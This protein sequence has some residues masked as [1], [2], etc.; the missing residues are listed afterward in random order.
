[1][2]RRAHATAAPA[3]QSLTVAPEQLRWRCATETLGFT[4]TSDVPQL[5]GTVGQARG[6]EAISLSLAIDSD[7]FNVY[8]AGPPGT[9]RASTVRRMLTDAAR[10]RPTSNDWCYLHNFDD[11]N[12]PVAVQLASGR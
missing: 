12:Q 2:P 7:G 10:D 11:P 1:M 9:G 6:L 8:V 4:S 5:A 3:D